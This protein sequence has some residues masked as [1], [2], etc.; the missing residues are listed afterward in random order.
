MSIVILISDLSKG[1][2]LSAIIKAVKSKKI[3]TEIKAV[4]ANS[5]KAQ[6]IKIA[7]KNNIKY[8]VY[9][10]KFNLLGLL[11]K[12]NPDYIVLAGWKNIIED[13]V[14]NKFENRIINLHPGLIPDKADEYVLNPD[15]TKGLWNRGK[16]QEDAISNFF[17]NKSTFAGSSVH[18][19]TNEFDFGPVLGRVFEK[20]KIDDTIQSLYSR[21][22]KKENLLYVDVLKNLNK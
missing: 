1:T 15:G 4:I 11:T 21:L 8:F 16:Y 13:S 5:D 14:I 3:K 2:N 9:P 22:K 10:K 12:L 19:L 17:K 18:F 20:I 7:K 6:G